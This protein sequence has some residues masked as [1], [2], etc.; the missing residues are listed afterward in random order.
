MAN[1]VPFPGLADVPLG[2]WVPFVQGGED[3]IDVRMD[4]PTSNQFEVVLE[5]VPAITWLKRIRVLD[6][7][8]GEMAT[9][10]TEN[11]FHGPASV[12]LPDGWARLEF[13]KA[14][15]FGVPTGMYVTPPTGQLLL[16]PVDSVWRLHFL[17]KK[18]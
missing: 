7:N 18:D 12:V 17:W 1:D 4:T 14:K 11:A 16:L 8:G 9:I 10:T 3:V 13:V 2:T 15:T 5:C 6:S